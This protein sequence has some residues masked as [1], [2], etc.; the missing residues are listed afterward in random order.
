MSVFQIEKDR[1]LVNYKIN[2]EVY[3]KHLLWKHHHQ[4]GRQLKSK[5]QNLWTSLHSKEE[6][7][8]RFIK[9]ANE[10]TMKTERDSEIRW[11]GP[12]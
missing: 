7:S 8:C 3:N 1:P 11:E 9:V 5:L 4:Q 2:L 10:L 12:M 6:S